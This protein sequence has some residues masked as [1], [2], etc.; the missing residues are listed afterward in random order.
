MGQSKTAFPVRLQ[1]TFRKLL[2]AEQP[3]YR[4]HLLRLDAEGRRRRFALSVSDGFITNYAT[5]AKEDGTIIF[6]YFENGQLRGVAELKRMGKAWGQ[7]AEAAFSVEGP[8]CNKGIATELMGRIIRS[9]RNRGV[10]HLILSCLVENAKMRAIA[11]KYGANLKLQ[12]G[13]V[14]ADIVPKG[15]D[16]VSFATEALEDRMGYWQAAL[17]S[18]TQRPAGNFN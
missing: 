13:S 4:D 16:F 18:G 9:A 12:E 8:Y 14:I 1:G 2:G 15:A 10:R 5:L 11:V 6:G 7:M 17:E 3:L